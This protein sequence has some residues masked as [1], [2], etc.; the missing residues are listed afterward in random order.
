MLSASF[1]FH[2]V[3]FLYMGQGAIFFFYHRHQEGPVWFV[4]LFDSSL[5]FLKEIWASLLVPRDPHL[6]I[7]L[8]PFL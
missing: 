5:P 4:T 8:D 3:I 6:G 1:G 7:V 2:T